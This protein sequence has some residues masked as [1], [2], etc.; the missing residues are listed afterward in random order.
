MKESKFIELL[1]LYVDHEINAEEAAELEAEI[2]QNPQRRAVY[3]QY[4]RIQKSCTVLAD[5]FRT[6][7][8]QPVVASARS[9]RAAPTWAY[10]GGLVAAAACASLVIA[11][12]W[13]G[14]GATQVQDLSSPSANSMAA[15]TRA[16]PTVAVAAVTPSAPAPASALTTRMDFQPVL[17]SHTLHF[18]SLAADTDNAMLTARD[19]ARLDWLQSVQL[20]PLSVPAENLR[21]DAR[22]TTPTDNRVYAGRK[23][24]GTA[25]MTAFQFQ[26]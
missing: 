2:Q 24:I 18:A 15:V 10:A 16:V 1:N 26:R 13:P 14:P 22:A 9:R 6:D 25:E 21:F 23:P 7:A 19:Q 11:T 8:P 17:V 5:Q 12:N 3:L 4:C 20:T